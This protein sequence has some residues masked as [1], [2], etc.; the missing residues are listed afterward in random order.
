M[1]TIQPNFT[2]VTP[3][4]TR[5]V[6]CHNLSSARAYAS[7]RLPNKEAQT[8]YTYK[9][10]AFVSPTGQ[11]YVNI[12]AGQQIVRMDVANASTALHYVRNGVDTDVACSAYLANLTR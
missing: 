11:Y 12:H 10:T 3:C 6:G 8:T 7:G 1:T 2:A 9:C 5:L 4:R